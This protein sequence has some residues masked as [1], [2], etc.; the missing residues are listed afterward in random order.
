MDKWHKDVL[1][2]KDPY[3]NC[4]SDQMRIGGGSGIRVP[5]IH[6]CHNELSIVHNVDVD[7][8]QTSKY[9]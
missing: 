4:G 8:E 1:P 9:I 3:H 7:V 6:S 5:V 2:D